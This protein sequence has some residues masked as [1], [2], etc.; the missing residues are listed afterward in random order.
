MIPYGTVKVINNAVVTNHP[1]LMRIDIVPWLGRLNKVRFFP[2]GPVDKVVGAGE[3][4]ERFRFPAGTEIKHD[5]KI[6]N[7]YHLRISGDAASVIN[8]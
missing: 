5:P 4:I 7:A 6:A 2:L 1:G 3:C 8:D